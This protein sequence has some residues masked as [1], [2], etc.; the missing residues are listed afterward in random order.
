MRAHR[1]EIITVEQPVELL[2]VERQNIAGEMIWPLEDLALQSLLPHAKTRSLVSRPKELPPRPLA[3]PCVSLSVHTAPITQ[4]CH[5]SVAN[6]Q[7]VSVLDAPS[8]SAK[9]DCDACD[10]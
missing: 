9:D 10:G 8:V 4:S 1:L 5:T 7:T 3:E 6:A 2:A